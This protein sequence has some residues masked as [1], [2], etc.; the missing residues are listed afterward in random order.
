MF[1]RDSRRERGQTLSAH[2]FRVF[3][4]HYIFEVDRMLQWLTKY[5]FCHRKD[6]FSQFC[7][8]FR[9]GEKMSTKAA[10]QFAFRQG[11][12][13]WGC[14]G[15]VLLQ[16]DGVGRGQFHRAPAKAPGHAGRCATRR[17][18]TAR[19]GL[20]APLA[21]QRQHT[22]ISKSARSGYLVILASSYPLPG[23]RPP[24]RTFL[25]RNT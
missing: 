11:P 3:H 7:L 24:A 12:G 13:R 14:K 2:Y 15:W 1:T 16:A 21:L 23:Q 17:T 19:W 22:L 10:H 25:L 5:N 18:K 8:L 6:D 4:A 20:G 9:R